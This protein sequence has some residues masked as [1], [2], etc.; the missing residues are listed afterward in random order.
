MM[1]QQPPIDLDAEHEKDMMAWL[2]S[3]KE[4][5]LQYDELSRLLLEEIK[6]GTPEARHASLTNLNP[7]LTD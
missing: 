7:Y 6:T 3:K 1:N 5:H 2:H 4:T